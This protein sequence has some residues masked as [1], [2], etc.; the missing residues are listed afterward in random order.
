MTPTA[1]MQAALADLAGSMFGPTDPGYDTAERVYNAMIDKSPALIVQART[2]ADVV[3]RSTPRAKGLFSPSAAAVTTA[4]VSAPATAVWSLTLR[5][6]HRRGGSRGQDR[7][8]RRWLHLGPG[9]SRPPARTGSLLRVGSSP[10][11][12]SAD[13][14]SAVALATYACL[15][16]RHRQPG[17]GG[18]RA[19]RRTQRTRQCIRG[20]RPVLGASRRRRQLRCGDVVHLPSSTT[21]PASSPGPP[22]GTSTRGRPVLKAYREFLPSAPSELNGFFAYDRCHPPHRSPRSST[23]AR[24]ALSC[25]LTSATRT[26]PVRRWRRCWPP[27][28]SRC[29]MASPTMP[30]AALQGAF[31]ALFPKGQQWYWRADFVNDIPD[32]A[33]DIHQRFGSALPTSVST[34]HLYPIDGAAHDVG[35]ER[36]RLGLPRR[37]LG[38]GVCG[39]R[40]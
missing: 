3:L 31:D 27:S 1:A 28:P 2:E 35:A 5:D 25:G 22:S 38:I 6:S 39:G 24:S 18:R 36:H 10:P 13:S 15:R 23:C 26:T 4:V 19:R 8:G 30:H 14:P 7:T 32:A 17:R 12:A 33:V 11:P 21:S 34:M 40:S 29:C 9:G 16:A 37:D 20:T